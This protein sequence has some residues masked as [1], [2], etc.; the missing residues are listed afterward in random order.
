MSEV[1]SAAVLGLVQGVTEF[2]PVSSS[3]HLV[4]F[5][6]I[7]GYSAGGSSVVLDLLL[8][9]GT[10]IAVFIVYFKDIIE[11]LK[12][13]CLC[14]RD[15]FTGKFSFKNVS[16]YRKFLFMIILSLLPLFVV[17][18]FKDTVFAAFENLWIVGS[19]LLLTGTFLIFSDR[20]K[21]GTKGMAET[22]A[23]DA[24][25]VG[26][27]Q[28][29]ATIPGISRSG[30]TITAGL[31]RGFSREYAVKFSFIMSLPAI[32]GAN[33]LEVPDAL[34]SGSAISPIAAIVGLAVSIVAGIL[35]IKLIKMIVKSQKF[36]FFGIYCLLAGSAVLIYQIV[37]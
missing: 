13:L 19:M 35:S 22:K 29:I 5:H 23:K 34:A 18:P 16:P 2:L 11:I 31:F 33:L 10:L 21:K 32:L 12:E 17:L 37:K 6:E 20:I 26:A 1:L 27:I 14:V 8:H 24:L 25:F 7:F 36:F 30:S 4:I 3:G 9:F 28:A 15:I